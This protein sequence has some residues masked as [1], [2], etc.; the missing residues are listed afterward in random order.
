MIFDKSYLKKSKFLCLVL[1]RIFVLIIFGNVAAML[2]QIS[3]GDPRLEAP[4]SNEIRKIF[5]CLNI[6]ILIVFNF[7]YLSIQ[8]S[9]I[10]ITSFPI[11]FEE[12]TELFIY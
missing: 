10:E 1:S 4:V 9:P 8:I 6:Y 2:S 7:F 11:Y 5:D 12:I 3:N